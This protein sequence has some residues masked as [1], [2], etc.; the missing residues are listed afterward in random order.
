[1]AWWHD[2]DDLVLTAGG[3]EIGSSA[4]D[5]ARPI[6]SAS[7][8]NGRSDWFASLGP[9][10][11][12]FTVVDDLSW[13]LPGDA[14][15]LTMGAEPLW[16]GKVDTVT[17]NREPGQPD[18]TTLTGTDFVGQLGEARLRNE[19][20]A[21]DSMDQQL[22]EVLG[23]ADLTA[24]VKRAP[25]AGDLGFLS[26]WLGFTGSV[27][28]WITAAEK[29]ANAI[30]ALDANGDIRV[31]GRAP[32]PDFGERIDDPAGDSF[33]SIPAPTSLWRMDDPST[34]IA[35]NLGV[36]NGT[37]IGTP[38]YGVEGAWGATGP[39]GVSF[40]KADAADGFQMGDVYDLNAATSWTIMGWARW[41]GPGGSDDV[42]VGK[43]AAGNDG[44]DITLMEATE[45]LRYRVREA[46]ATTLTM[47]TGAS[48]VPTAEWFWWAVVRDTT[49]TRLYLAT[50]PD[51][52]VT[53]MDTD[54]SVS[55]PNTAASFT[56]G[57]LNGAS[58]WYG[59]R[60]QMLAVWNADALGVLQM[61][62]LIDLDLVD[63]EGAMAP[64]S[65]SEQRSIT[66]VIN[67]WEIGGVTT[68]DA[69][70]IGIYGL[71][72]WD[73]SDTLELSGDVY[74]ADLMALMADPRPIVT[75]TLHVTGHACDEVILLV[76]L[77]LVR[78][79]GTLW[80]VLEVRHEIDLME[81]RT[82]LTL[83]RSQSDLTS[84]VPVLPV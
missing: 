40:Q 62:R 74:G 7:F 80:Q 4:S 26:E 47:T 37:A 12:S 10:S 60:Q 84:E 23:I 1:M 11:A 54:T 32:L 33:P 67:H 25:F 66:S 59:G 64:A 9:S 42:L 71:R 16:T 43:N 61:Q 20:I 3:V 34:G 52:Q 13:V 78:Y 31:C 81:W 21:T 48:T 35:D 79:D 56:V 29:Y 49:T 58:A 77:D 30:V 17:L 50:A 38:G 63:L 83:D 45:Q 5:S 39:T 75:T 22:V 2:I 51:Y 28:D 6:A 57:S 27:L 82:T 15:V 19:T 68:K 44:W 14:L 70:S 46:S 53:I 69:V 41:L 76:P 55:P 18:T 65:W 72:T 8:S 36:A 73:V 24:T